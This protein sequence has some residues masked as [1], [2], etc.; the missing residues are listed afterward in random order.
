[1]GG[2][3]QDATLKKLCVLSA[4][5]FTAEAWSL[6]TP[7]T[8]KNCFVKC[9]FSIDHVSSGDSA[10]KLSEEDDWHN[11]QP[12]GVQFEDCTTCDSALEFCGFQSIQRVDQ[13]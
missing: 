1:M 12:C 13:V 7:M 3:L 10:V 2:L 6:I 4:V 11:L 8:I 5:H 9:D